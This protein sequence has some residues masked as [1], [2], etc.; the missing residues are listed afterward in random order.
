MK[1]LSF[2]LAALSFTVHAFLDTPSQTDIEESIV[3]LNNETY[4]PEDYIPAARIK[5]RADVVQIDA[6]AHILI[7]KA[8]NE[9][10]KGSIESKFD[11]LNRNFEPWGYRFNLKQVTIMISPKWASGIDIE[12]D[13]K[14]K[15]LRKGNYQALNVY[16]VETA[17]GAV[18]SFPRPA[19][20]KLTTASVVDDGCF[21]PLGLGV[22]SATITHEVGHWMGLAHVFE[23]GCDSKDG[24]DDTFP[25]A[26]A[27]YGKLATPGDKKSCPVKSQCNG[28]GKQNVLNYVSTQSIC[29][30][31]D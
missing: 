7:S 29:Q 15:A 5:A 23:G 12:K 2:A 27:S 13:E 22:N 25:Q 31:D 19:S 18:C 24:C 26:E 30:R 17:G 28:K 1:S 8:S 9:P 4:H 3:C 16:M 11:T 21:V 6:Y 10:A 14:Q 20:E